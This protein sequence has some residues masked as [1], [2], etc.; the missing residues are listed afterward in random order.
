MERALS[1]EEKY[2]PQ[3]L[4]EMCGHERE[5]R[6]LRD[7][8]ASGDCPHLLLVGPPGTGKT[9]VAKIIGN[10]IVGPDGEGTDIHEW[11]ASDVRGIDFVRER[12]IPFGRALPF[13]GRRRVVVLDEAD[14]L[15]KEAMDALKR[16][17]EQMA[18]NCVFIFT[19]NDETRFIPALKSRL[20]VLR[21]DGIPAE[22]AAKWVLAL[23]TREGVETDF[24]SVLTLCQM[25]AE[26]SARET[27]CDGVDMRKAIQS[28]R[29][30]AP[31]VPAAM[32]VSPAR[33]PY[34]GVR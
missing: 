6:E 2:R 22:A 8:L 32:A 9:T 17:M 16:P 4:D 24:P 18:R 13:G 15:T 28:A 5:I 25:V 21:F 11:N 27:L 34:V 1:W 12:I 26:E 31:A 14:G 3:T 23:L 33:A 20:R 7:Y 30:L 29:A 10:A 19:A